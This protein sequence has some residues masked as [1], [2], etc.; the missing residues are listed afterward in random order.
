MQ[1]DEM[2]S[3]KSLQHQGAQ[4]EVVLLSYSKL[5][6]S[7]LGDQSVV[8]QYLLPCASI[9]CNSKVTEIFFTT[10]QWRFEHRTVTIGK[11]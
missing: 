4:Q 7:H 3:K 10:S 2:G 1:S 6:L 9:C 8:T 11:T 5:F